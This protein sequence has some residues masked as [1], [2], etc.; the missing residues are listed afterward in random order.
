MTHPAY[1]RPADL[2]GLAA[3]LLA[4]RGRPHWSELATILGR[5]TDEGLWCGEIQESAQDRRSGGAPI[6][7]PPPGG[8]IVEP[9]PGSG[10]VQRDNS[11]VEGEKPA[12]PEQWAA[13]TLDLSR[14]QYRLSMRLWGLI[15]RGR[16]EADL[17]P[18][19][20]LGVSQQKALLLDE[21]VGAG[22]TLRAW[23]TNAVAMSNRAFRVHVRRW[24]KQQVWVRFPVAR[25][26]EDLLPVVDEAMRRALPYVANDPA[27]NPAT[28]T[29]EAWGFRCLELVL[30][31]FVRDVPVMKATDEE[32]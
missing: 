23:W 24:L 30:V 14:G 6:D 31:K 32:A 10:D 26:P 15:K 28:W 4:P 5:I 27:A 16:L 12:S 19:A 2:V 18:E 11:P 3:A 21:V 25:I 1:A 20:W 8:G 17:A 13:D 7:V 22:G 29:D 9:A